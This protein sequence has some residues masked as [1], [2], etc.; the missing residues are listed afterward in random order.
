MKKLLCEP[1][2]KI[3][4]L[5]MSF[6][7]ETCFS[8]PELPVLISLNSVQYKYFKIRFKRFPPADRNVLENLCVSLYTNQQSYEYHFQN[9]PFYVRFKKRVSI[10]RYLKNIYES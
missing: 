5:F 4:V 2:D 1:I 10:L 6:L 8:M 7:Q 3:F 9:V